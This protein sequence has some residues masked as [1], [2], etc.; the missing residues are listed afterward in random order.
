MH[1]SALCLFACFLLGA[2]DAQPT[3]ST[4]EVYGQKTS[5]NNLLWLI[6]KSNTKPTTVETVSSRKK[7]HTIRSHY[8]NNNYCNDIM[9][10]I[11][12]YNC[13]VE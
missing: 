4:G 6:L 10:W 8:N 7:I 12:N 9:L 13:S 3:D 11:H 2:V 1:A 5:N